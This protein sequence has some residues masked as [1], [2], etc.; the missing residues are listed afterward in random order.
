MKRI[1]SVNARPDVNG[2]GKKGFHDNADL[3]GQRCNLF[4][5]NMAE[6][7]PRRVI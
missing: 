3:S 7:N 5:A 1:D 2:E 4:N 6:C